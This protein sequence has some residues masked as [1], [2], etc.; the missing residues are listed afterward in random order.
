MKK[1]IKEYRKKVDACDKSLEHIANLI[2]KARKDKEDISIIEDLK[3]E[4][5]NCQTNRR[6][7]YQFIKDVE[8]CESLI[9]MDYLVDNNNEHGTD[10]SGRRVLRIDEQTFNKMSDIVNSIK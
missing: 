8:S 6:M 7:Y 10:S 4:K 3:G 5:Y 9:I 1:L 2:L